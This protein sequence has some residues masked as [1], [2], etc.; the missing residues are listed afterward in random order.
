MLTKVYVCS[1]YRGDVEKNEKMARSY[2][3]F[4]ARQ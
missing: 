3:K 4:I 2:S 1:P